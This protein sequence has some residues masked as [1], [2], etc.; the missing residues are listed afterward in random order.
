[1]AAIFAN[2]T[3]AAFDRYGT[4]RDARG[5]A[6]ITY[7]VVPSTAYCTL[8]RPI[9]PSSSAILR[10]VYVGVEAN[11]WDWRGG[12]IAVAAIGLVHALARVDGIGAGVA[13]AVICQHVVDRV[14]LAADPAAWSA[15]AIDEVLEVV[16][17]ARE[18]CELLHL[19]DVVG[20]EGAYAERERV[21]DVLG[22]LDRVGV[23]A[24]LRG[25]AEAAHQLHFPGGG[26]VE[27]TALADEG[28]H[29]RR[30]RQGF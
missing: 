20:D 1:M 30:V 15:R 7:T 29:H 12:V 27:E 4:V 19:I 6:S 2:D 3:P 8:I 25:N 28:L 24:A 16:R 10:V 5:L 26:Q 22:A 17:A 21:G 9:T 11:R 14:R 23:D 13:E 18:A